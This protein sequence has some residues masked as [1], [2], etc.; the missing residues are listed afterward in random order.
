MN[1]K[2]IGAMFKMDAKQA[3]FKFDALELKHLERWTEAEITPMRQEIH[4]LY[5]SHRDPKTI[6]MLLDEK[7]RFSTAYTKQTKQIDNLLSHELLK[8]QSQQLM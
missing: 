4:R 3:H 2:E 1:W 6:R 5:L 7:F 8:L